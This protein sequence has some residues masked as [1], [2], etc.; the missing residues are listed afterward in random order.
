MLPLHARFVDKAEA[1]LVAAI[2]VYNKPMF[3]YR[4]ETFSLLA[5]N[6]WELL[7][8]ARVLQLN[9]NDVRSIWV[10][11]TRK[12]KSGET[13]KK[14]YVDRNRSKTAKT[15]SLHACIK[16]LDLD[17]A[18][19]IPSE[20][21]SNIDAL[22]EIRDSSAHFVTASAVLRTQ[23]LSVAV[24]SVKNFV[25]LTRSWFRRDFS[26][27]ISIMLPLAFLSPGLKVNSVL[28]MND[29]SRLIQYLKEVAS[30]AA[31]D[32]S[33]YDVAVNV[34]VHL[35]RSK[36]DSAVKVQV[37]NDPNAT[38][39]TLTEQDI[40]D[41]YPWTFDALTAQL[42]KRYSDFIANSKY[43]KLRKQFSADPKYGRERLLDFDKPKGLK[44]SYFS[45]AILNEFDK[46]YTRK[47]PTGSAAA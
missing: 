45:P 25:L 47:P 29:E 38:R 13:S 36:L 26:D 17:A 6:A 1:A 5:I 33:V 44:K 14:K 18:S 9:S 43:H 23:V 11:V 21:Q 34:E 22:C 31:N 19:R 24:A 46:H 28:V 27:R 37:T 42:K 30:A 32:S 39:V 10:Y 7:L 2:E 16:R 12:T 41:Q 15:I 8:K 3:E 20:V 35:K 4:E 40:R